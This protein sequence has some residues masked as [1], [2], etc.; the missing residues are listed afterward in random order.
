MKGVIGVSLLKDHELITVDDRE[1]PTVSLE[2][3]QVHDRTFN[4]PKA[5]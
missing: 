3:G 2:G 1:R 4:G 5:S